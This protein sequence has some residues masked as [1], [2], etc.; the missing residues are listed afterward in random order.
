METKAEITRKLEH[1]TDIA[2]LDLLESG[3]S[4]SW[5][6]TWLSPYGAFIKWFWIR[7]GYTDGR[8]GWFLGKY[9]FDYTRKKYRKARALIRQRKS[10]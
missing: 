3:R 5:W 1:Y 6:K 7:K 2:A 9:A 10:N 8:L 4:V